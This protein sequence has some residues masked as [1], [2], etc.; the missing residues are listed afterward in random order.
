MDKD[1]VL[2]PEFGIDLGANSVGWAVI[3]PL[4]RHNESPL[5]G[6]GCRCFDA[7]VDGDIEKGKEE[8]RNTARRMARQQRRMLM[9]RSRRRL[10]LLHA[11]QEAGL[12]PAGDMNDPEIRHKAILQLDSASI[13]RLITAPHAANDPQ[14]SRPYDPAYHLIPYLLR[15]RAL[16]E[17]LS[18]HE[19]GRALYHLGHRRGYLSNRKINEEEETKPK[20]SSKAKDDSAED[21]AAPPEMGGKEDAGKVKAGIAHLE[22]LMKEAGSR[23]LGEYFST[24]DPQ[25]N[26]IRQRW[27]AR[28]MYEHEFNAIWEAQRK[29]HPDL[30]TDEAF[31]TI[32]SA[33]FHQRP[34]KSQSHLIGKCEMEPTQRRAPQAH[35]LAQR[36]RVL[37]TVNNL[38]LLDEFDRDIP[39]NSEQRLA[40]LTHLEDEGDLTFPRARKLLK[41]KN[42]IRFNLETGGEKRLV[43]NRTNAK[44]RAIFGGRWDEFSQAQRDQAVEDVITFEK[45]EPL[46]KRGRTHWQLKADKAE[47]FSKTQLE[48]AR[49][50]ISLRAIRKLLPLLEEG[51]TFGEARRKLYPSRFEAGKT[52]DF[53]PPVRKAIPTLR[54]PIVMRAL[55]EL[56][57]VVNSLIRRYGKP[58]AI[59]VELTRELRK[60]QDKRKQISRDM[61]DNERLREK[62]KERIL[63]EMGYQNPSGRDIEKVLLAE[64]CR[65]ECPYTGKQIGMRALIGPEPQF[66]VEHIIPYSRS[67]DNRFINKT[68]CYADE[69]RNRKKGHTPHEAY[70]S[71]PERWQAILLRVKKFASAFAGA[72]LR[73][74][75]AEEL[76]D[77]DE[78][79]ERQLRDTAYAS[80]LATE[81]LGLLYGGKV[82]EAGKLRVQVSSGGI[83]SILRRE[84][85]LNTILHEEDYK[86]RTDHRHHAIDALV[87]SLTTPAAV[88]NLS[89]AAVSGQKKG[90]LLDVLA[91]PWPG[92]LDHTRAAI[93]AIVVSHRVDKRLAGKLHD[94]S[95]YS[96]PIIDPKNPPK[97]GGT[98]THHIRKHLSTITKADQIEDIVDPAIRRIVLDKFNEVLARGVRPE[99]IFTD[100][101]NH[102]HMPITK[103]GR[104]IPIHKVRIRKTLTTRKLGSDFNPRYVVPGSNNHMEIVA[105]LDMNGKEKKLEFNVVTRLEAHRRKKAGIPITQTDHGL[106]RKFK[107]SLRSGEAIKVIHD[108]KEKILLVR[109]V[110]E[111]EVTCSDNRDARPKKEIIKGKSFYRLSPKLLLEMKTEKIVLD[112]LGNIH[113]AND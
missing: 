15:A 59:R 96:N 84:W 76:P 67:I 46:R 5:L 61:R 98:K 102:P 55:S 7:A 8:S 45:E 18:P 93:D 43:G 100:E 40:I 12:F 79:T 2:G 70:S 54:N 90:R 63:K 39:L 25:I 56:R 94:D 33:I 101:T 44:M 41:L 20:K 107:F 38:C 23:T 19:L 80:R 113:P 22:K 52:C 27:T 73:R 51:V 86:T 108:E 74:F 21:A 91:E 65:W 82:D 85:N 4:A 77:Q 106:A 1:E 50:S 92:F 57:K 66:D 62:A 72:K 88:K 95:L 35:L 17:K 34:L 103:D 47:E 60:T 9:R 10:K 75:Q 68:L 58:A 16:D 110:T 99:K 48:P 111:R 83:T 53:L 69:N 81:Y 112:P 3:Q 31:K 29:H 109:G 37:Q 26:R 11:F 87:V 97:E 13:A 24:L 6:A 28:S 42:T 49:S 32:K 64:E 78:F 30:L 105:V 89:D 36:F 104:I 71:D 14:Q